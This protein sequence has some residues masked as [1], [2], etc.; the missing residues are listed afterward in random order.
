MDEGLVAD[1]PGQ[2]MPSWTEISTPET[3]VGWKGGGNRRVE[4][5]RGGEGEVGG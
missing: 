3:K 5:V 2:S 1:A 4:G